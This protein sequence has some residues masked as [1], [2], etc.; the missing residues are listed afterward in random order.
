[1]W[2]W[3][4][5]YNGGRTCF[6]DDLDGGGAGVEMLVVVKGVTWDGAM[7]VCKRVVWCVRVM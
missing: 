2:C 3:W 4:Y 7:V 6:G 5:V 1:M